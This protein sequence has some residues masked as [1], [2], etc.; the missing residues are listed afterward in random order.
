MADGKV[1][2]ESSIDTSRAKSDAKELKNIAYDAA[3]SQ[4]QVASKIAD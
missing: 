4:G 2:I 1:I 3:T